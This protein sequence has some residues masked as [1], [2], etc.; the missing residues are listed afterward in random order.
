MS[1]GGTVWL[2]TS[3]E[4]NESIGTQNASFF[5]S[6]HKTNIVFNIEGEDENM[7][8]KRILF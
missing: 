8:L 7:L 4:I 5:F 1:A 2:L 3:S 6:V